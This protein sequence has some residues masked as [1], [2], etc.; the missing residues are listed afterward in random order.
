MTEL[1]A[2]IDGAA[3]MEPEELGRRGVE[4][5]LEGIEATLERFGVHMDRYARE[6]ATHEADAVQAAIDQLREAG[7]STSRTAPRGCGPPGSG[8]TRTACWCARPAR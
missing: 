3:D 5:M 7:T 8:T 1:A 6:S 2:R 4:L